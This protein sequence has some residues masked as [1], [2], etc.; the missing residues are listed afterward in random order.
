MQCLADLGYRGVT[1]TEGLGAFAG[2]APAPLSTDRKKLVAITFDDGFLDFHR[3]AFPVLSHYGFSATMYIAT[4]F[5]ADDRRS[6]KGRECLTW[7]EVSELHQAGV[8]FGSHTVNHPKLVDLAW[9]EIEH[10]LTASKQEMENRLGETVS[11][12]AYPFAFPQANRPFATRFRELLVRAGYSNCV[13]TAIGRGRLDGDLYQLPRLPVNS[14]DDQSLL[15]AKLVGAYDWMGLPQLL[16][17]N[18]QRF[19]RQ[20]KAVCL[21]L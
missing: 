11:S 15:T 9:P 18:T 7:S 12:F 20:S 14:E 3:G 10:E 19:L 4:A 5:I 21:A 6:F 16:R 17:K 2:S 1:L 8:E 13:T